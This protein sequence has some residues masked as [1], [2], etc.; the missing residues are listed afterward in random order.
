MNHREAVHRVFRPVLT[1]LTSAL[2]L[3]SIVACGVFS[4]D[5]TPAPPSTAP[6]TSPPASASVQTPSP[7]SMS[8]TAAEDSELYRAIWTNDVDTVKKLV[9]EGTDVNAK[10]E[11]GDPFLLE[12]IWRD[13]AE[14]VQV[15]V[16]AGADANARD[17]DG[18]PL[19]RE[20]IWRSHA[21]VA[22]IL[23]DAGADVE[24]SRLRRQSSPVRSHMEEPS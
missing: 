24:R 4:S 7:G 23:I 11:D 16:D 6:P 3:L 5:A 15:L 8:T 17:S 20:A 12:A 18:N 14:V 19:L 22:Q 13:H 1:P 10:D 9:A 2:A 21:D